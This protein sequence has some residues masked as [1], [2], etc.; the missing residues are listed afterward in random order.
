MTHLISPIISNR[1][2]NILTGTILGGS[3]LVK[4][5]GSRNC[6]LSMRNKELRWLEFKAQEIESLASGT[7]FTKDTTNRWHSMCYPIFNQL[8]Q[9]FY[10]ENKRKLKMESMDML[11]DV[12]YAVWFG[13]AGTYENNQIV[14]NTHVWGEE[15][16]NLVV[17][18]F[19]EI[20]FS[21]EVTR[22]RGSYRVKLNSESSLA[23]FRLAEPH[24]PV[25]FL[26]ER[27]V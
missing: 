27:F 6:Y 9:Q 4:A 8:R 22:E 14:L 12:A 16:S 17:Q 1:Q 19:N 25:W 26:R 24:L 3:S 23:F 18:Y 15:G 10:E 13:D 7:P 21:S 5:N 11:N 20:D 2:K